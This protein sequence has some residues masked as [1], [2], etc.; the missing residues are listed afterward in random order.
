MEATLHSPTALKYLYLSCFSKPKADRSLY[1]H[2]RRNRATH[3]VELGMGS[4]M[5]SKRMLEVAA[6]YARSRPVHYT[7]IDLFDDRPAGEQPRRLI[8][9]Y[10][11]LKPSEARLRLVP[12]TAASGLARVANELQET[13]LLLISAAQG[14]TELTAAW[15]F[16]PRMLHADSLVLRETSAREDEPSFQPVGAV[17]IARLAQRTPRRQAA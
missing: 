1:R 2:L 4:V 13:D 12:G 7:V 6:R 8:D 9:V 10:R 3:I 14:T 11:Q 16:V 17:E 15:F 5:R